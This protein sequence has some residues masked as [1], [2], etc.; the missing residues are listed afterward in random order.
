MSKNT[1]TD[2]LTNLLLWLQRGAALLGVLYILIVAIGK[3]IGSGSPGGFI[4]WVLAGIAASLLIGLIHLGFVA[5]NMTYDWLTIQL[6]KYIKIRRGIV[7]G[8]VIAVLV[9]AS[10]LVFYTQMDNLLRAM[11]GV[12]FLLMVPSAITSM[13]QEDRRREQFAL[14]G[15]RI[16]P[17]LIAQNPQ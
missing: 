7:I 17:D 8:F 12:F 16:A 5:W 3:G 1:G 14:I 15:S 13:L 4:L 9:L 10:L 6:G 2:K 11:I